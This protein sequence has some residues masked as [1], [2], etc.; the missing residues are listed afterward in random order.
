MQINN[1]TL[2]SKLRAKNQ[3]EINAVRGKLEDTE[4]E[5]SNLS[6][7]IEKPIELSQNIHVYW[8]L[9][10][11]EVRKKIQKTILPEGI[12]VDTTNRI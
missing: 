12:V 2:Y 9:G 7:Y 10:N 6:Y 1:E 8:Q 5:I 11:L 4:I 3:S